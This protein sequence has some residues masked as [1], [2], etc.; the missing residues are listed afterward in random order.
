MKRREI[1]GVGGLSP[2]QQHLGVGELIP[3]K[4]YFGRQPVP[5]TTPSAG[6]SSL[7]TSR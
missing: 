5:E 2:N 6:A 7:S 4:L 1:V 3:N